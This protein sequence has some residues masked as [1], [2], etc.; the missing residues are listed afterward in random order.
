MDR[1]QIEQRIASCYRQEELNCATT[2][3]KILAEK[4]H[5]KLSDQL[6]DAAVGMHGAGGYQAQCGLVEG[7]ILFLGIVGRARGLGDPEI[8]DACYRY[9][10]GF[11]R[12]FSSLLCRE[13]RPEG[14]SE[15]QPPHL[16]EG[17][18]CDSVAFSSAF[19]DDY[20]SKG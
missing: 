17:L 10:E 15:D 5:I 7:T 8:I 16:C 18:T 11:E 4:C 2:T 12:R 13:L 6:L 3:L 1:Q 9:A 19:L 20:I 14:F